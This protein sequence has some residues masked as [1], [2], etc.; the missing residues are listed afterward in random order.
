MPPKLNVLIVG[1]GI[2]GP[3]LAFWLSRC[4]HLVT[5]IERS[6]TLRDSGAQIDLRAQ[7]ISVIRSMGLMQTLREHLVDEAGVAHVDAQGRV[8]ATIMAN[9][10][11]RGAQSVTSEYEIMRGD[12]VRILYD[13]T[14][15]LD[16]V[17]YKFG[18]TI[19]RFE[20]DGDGVT[21]WYSDRNTEKFDVL[22]G[23]DGQGSRV[24]KAIL[25]GSGQPDPLHSLGVSMAYWNIPRTKHDSNIRQ[26]YVV[27]NRW[28]FCRSHSPDETQAYFF[29][30]NNAAETKAIP[31]ASL[32]EQKEFW[33]NN[34]HGA[35]W[36]TSR[37]IEGMKT[38][39]NFY[40]QE[41][42]QIKSDTWSKGRVVLLGDAAHCP[43]P[44]SG[45]GTTSAL[46]GA[47]VLAGEICRRSDDLDLAFANYDRT[48]RPFANEVQKLKPFQIQLMFPSTYLGISILHAIVRLLCW[49]CVPDLVN[50]FSKEDKGGWK[51]PDYPELGA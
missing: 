16:G 11:G 1:A 37:F 43:S 15:D 8:I 45:M 6:G 36:Q 2:A 35:G 7:G 25:E 29:L 24:R 12:L 30:R 22:V 19:E 38:A 40:C 4:G 23:G 28:I 33:I 26:V 47:Y 10:T 49:L 3:A 13:A 32:D 44:L 41:A 21:V 51:L 27:P 18:R 17:S 14:K 46:V 42:V 48:M 31:K 9:R 34:F 50:R 5:V 39:E 20:Q